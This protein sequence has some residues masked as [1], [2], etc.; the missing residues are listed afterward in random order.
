[1][2][3]IQ[4]QAPAT[5]SPLGLVTAC[6]WSPSLAVGTR[7]TRERSLVRNQPRPFREGPANSTDVPKGGLLLVDGWHRVVLPE[8]GV[9]PLSAVVSV[10]TSLGIR[11]LGGGGV[12]RDSL[13]GGISADHTTKG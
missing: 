12:S 11:V 2:E 13:S 3:P 5:I 10:L 7:F 1:M 4:R 8:R 6:C 9:E